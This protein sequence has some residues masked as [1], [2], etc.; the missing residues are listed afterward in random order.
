[1]LQSVTV[2]LS[3]CIRALKSLSH[4][5]FLMRDPITELQGVACLMGSRNVTCHLTQANT[6][7][8]NPSKKGWYSIYIPGGMEG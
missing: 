6:P 8:I 1:M 5:K 2:H 3:R 7:C 4:D